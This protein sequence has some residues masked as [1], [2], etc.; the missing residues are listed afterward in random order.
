MS[1]AKIT[2]ISFNKYM[3]DIGDDL[4]KYLRLPEGIDKDTLTGNILMRGGEFEVV[5]SDP[6]FIQ[7]SISIWSS[8]W[9]RT[10]E[11]WINA[12]N[13]DYNPLENYDRMEEWTDNRNKKDSAT[14]NTEVDNSQKRAG[15][16]SYNDDTSENVNDRTDTENKVSAFDSDSYQP[17]DKTESDYTSQRSSSSDGDTSEN[18]N[19]TGNTTSNGSH[20]GTENEDSK[21]MG[22]I[23]GNI[24]VL[25]SQS[26]L[27]S[28]LQIAEWNVYEHITDLF[29]SEYVIPIYS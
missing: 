25:T 29:L 21:H 9:Y 13:I 5:Y 28:E 20:S 23:H 10:F 19:I 8:K 1:S 26:M 14:D 27:E 3:N 7:K 16:T 15:S 24:G 4:F 6:E 22:R 2:L 11:K 18:V 17:H 12:L